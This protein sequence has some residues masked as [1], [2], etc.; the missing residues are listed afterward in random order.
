M[1]GG[2]LRHVLW[3]IR[4]LVGA[5]PAGDASDR[6]LLARFADARDQDAFAELVRRHGPL[7]WGV[8]RRRL[9][10]EQD[11]EDAFQATFLVLA[12]KASA[13][14]WQASVAGWL[15]ETARRTAQK[16]RAAAARRQ[17]RERDASSMRH[18]PPD[19]QANADDLREILSVE[20]ARLPSRY[21]EPLLLCAVEGLTTEEA[22]RRLGCP[23]G[24]I[25]SRL[26]RGRERLRTTLIRRG[27]TL[28]AAGLAGLL[29]QEAV[30]TPPR[31]LVESTITAALSAAAGQ[32]G[33]SAA[34]VLAQE[35]SRTMPAFL[36]KI[37]ATILLA[38]GLAIGYRLSV[39]VPQREPDT[40]PAPA[41]QTAEGETPRTDMHSD[42]LPAGAVARLGTTRL[43]Q[44]EP[45]TALAFSP[46]GT[47][48][49]SGGRDEGIVYLWDAASGKQLRRCLGHLRPTGAPNARTITT[50]AFCPDGKTVASIGG[51]G[52][53]R[54]WEVD[55]GRE[56]RRIGEQVPTQCLA[57]S[58]DGKLLAAGTWDQ[59]I[60]LWEVASG[61]E[62]AKLS[63]HGVVVRAVAFTPD[64]KM[65][66]SGGDDGIIRLWDVAGRKEVGQLTGHKGLV[67]HL[68]FLADG[69]TLLSSGRDNT[70][71]VWDAITRKELRRVEGVHV[72]TGSF[73]VS[74][75]GKLLAAPGGDY[76]RPSLWEIA[77]GKKLHELPGHSF[78]TAAFAF[79]RDGKRVTAGGQANTIHLWDV[80]TGKAVGPAGGHQAPIMG[81]GFCAG[82]QIVV[83]GGQYEPSLR[84]WDAT[85]G[86]ELRQLPTERGWGSILA[87]SPDGKTLATSGNVDTL[88]DIASGKKIREWKGHQ[89]GTY[90]LAFSP[91]GK[92]L[93][94]ASWNN[95]PMRLWDAATS[96]ELR[97][98]AHPGNISDFAFSPDG[99][100]LAVGGMTGSVQLLD[101]STGKLLREFG[102]AQEEG[103]VLAFAPDGKTLA[104]GSRVSAGRGEPMPSKLRLWELATGR[105]RQLF[106][107]K[108][109]GIRSVAFCPD[110]RTL[111][112]AG[113]T[114]IWLWDA[115]TGKALRHLEG[116]DGGVTTAVLSPDGSRV[117]SAGW[118]TT[119]LV[120]D[121]ADLVHR[122]RSESPKL[123]A[124]EFDALW[125]NLAGSD[126]A[127]AGQAMGQLLAAREHT[128]TLFKQH[129][130]PAQPADPQRLAS[131]LG[132][133]DSEQFAVRD[134]ASQEIEKLGDLAEPALRKALDKSPP[135]EARRRLEQLLTQVEGGIPSGERL[136]GLRAVEVLEHIGTPEAR[137]LLKKLAEGAPEAHLT[138]EAKA[139]L[140]RL[141]NPTR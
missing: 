25:K 64:G 101:P 19:T 81:I 90:H 24:T 10:H 136:R 77:T 117:A 139:A 44:S 4:S 17:A 122:Q 59:L 5:A 112:S 42:P 12:R 8:C 27:V 85:T 53:V 96:K 89:L 135:P 140:E 82:G 74:P 11:A 51:D 39:S 54:L 20:L 93:A 7:V 28:S 13:G 68:A 126:A 70:L 87:V 56:I 116:H 1:A 37:A 84:V 71:R 14:G 97:Q 110:G 98:V 62:I 38:V 102:Q 67:L 95:D 47:V 94:S 106:E 50:I 26:A 75:D 138:R 30:A 127:K 29:A 88:W 21:R 104:V 3:H 111:V 23:P 91:D 83:T 79:S 131:L 124:E 32:L 137:E 52:G 109:L 103:L 63:G 41:R 6:A 141:R 33:T 78:A 69:K 36:L 115:A 120:W 129:I 114:G 128:V 2:Q 40:Q 65:L 113:G 66:A 123:S 31:P 125:T 86:K 100:V 72:Q 43:R 16:A 46:D 132:D 134:K 73:A 15:Y 34:A 58:D 9:C 108:D 118:D 45:V 49:A 121:V 107:K 61:K 92:F 80:A 119:A 76:G 48:L 130:R 133:L 57:L 60:Y 55:T 18:I 99:K 22:A 105:V 35:V